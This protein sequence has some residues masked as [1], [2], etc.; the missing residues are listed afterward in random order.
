M[1]ARFV[2]ELSALLQLLRHGK[3]QQ[4]REEVN[5]RL[6]DAMRASPQTFS[7]RLSPIDIHIDNNTSADWSVVD[8]TPTIPRPSSTACRMPWPCV[9]YT[10]TASPSPVMH[11][12][13]QDQLYVGRQRGGKITSEV[14]QRELRLIVTLIKQFTLFLTVAP[15]PAKALR[16]FDQ[17]L[18][19][20][21]TPETPS[22]DWHW[23]G[24][25]GPLKALATVL[26]SSDFLWED[27]L[28][29]QHASLLPVLKDLGEMHRRVDKTALASGL[30][31]ALQT[32]DTL[33][34][35]KTVLN[36]YKDRELFRIDMRHLLHPELPFGSFSAELTDLAE[37]VLATALTLA[38]QTL[39]QRHGTPQ[40]P[41]GS[42]CTFA[43]F[44]LGKLGGG[45]LGY[46]SDIEM[47][48]VYSG[49]GT[50]RGGAEQLAVSE[51][52]ELLVQQCRD[53]IVAR[54][55]GIFELDMRLRPFGSHGPLATSVDTFQQYYSPGGQAAPFERQALIKLRWVA[56]DA[57]L[58]QHIAAHRDGFV[59][60]AIPF[61]LAAAVQ[62]RQRQMQEL[63]SPGSTDTKYGPGGLID[64][65]YTVQYLQLLHGATTP[66][67]RT[68]NTLEA[69]QALHQAGHLRL[70]EYQQLRAAYIFLRRLID[71]LRVV[72][73]HAHDLVLP[74]T[75]SEAFTFLA[76]R[77]GYWGGQRPAARL[78]TD[79]T[80]HMAQAARI[81]QERFLTPSVPH[82][83]L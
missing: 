40:Q 26:G 49:Q 3:L 53:F 71:A 38:H 44:G 12:K 81:Y 79:I 36:T 6:I 54:R 30:Q 31:Q 8:I 73:G 23:L 66:S 34:A 61:D 33:A 55:A 9:I 19:R 28:R 47:L 57:T 7:A 72:R 56:G 68:P 83:C 80:H 4:A 43:L 20:L 1:Q 76:R 11:G 62:L 39:Q 51:Y 18:D 2:T 27:F 58:G 63:V 17:L 16:H 67:V 13:V 21:A 42:P 82:P 59:Y 5:S 14:G 15:D 48:C 77:M 64:V 35:R 52:A 74:P 69:L 22:E 10:F 25:E 75:D 46:A 24:E 65:E 37:V 50:T 78:A 70:Q 45:E 29:M 41:D 60:S 32:A